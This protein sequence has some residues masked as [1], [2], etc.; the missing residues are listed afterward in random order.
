MARTCIGLDLG[1]RNLRLVA[2]TIKGTVFTVTKIAQAEVKL[3]DDPEAAILAALP[4]L[5]AALGEKLAKKAGGARFGVSGKE[6]IIRYTQVP[7]VPLWRLRL[8]MDFEV[9][10]MAAQA[11]DSLASDYNLVTLPNAGQGEDTVLV[12]VCKESFLAARFD[13]VRAEIGDPESALPAS[14]A[15]FNA[16]VGSGDIHEGEYTFL[17]DLGDRN[18]ELA[19]QRDGELIFARNIATGGRALTEAIAAALQTSVEDAEGLKHQFGSVT[20]RGLATYTSGREEKVGNAI[21]GPVGQLSAMIQSSLAFIRA[22]TKI[23]DLEVGRILLS[24]GGANLR[25]LP[26]YLGAAFHCPVGRFQPEAGLDLTQLEPDEAALFQTDPGS[27]AVALG[28]A[29]TGADAQA[30][31]LDLVPQQTKKKRRFV[32]RSLFMWLAGAAALIFL[33]LTLVREIRA[34]NEL[35]ATASNERRLAETARTKRKLY[36]TEQAKIADLN[37]KM[38]FLSGYTEPAWAL[39]TV[40]ELV[41]KNRPENVWIQSISVKRDMMADAANP[42]LRAPKTR[43][44][45]TGMATTMNDVPEHSLQLLVQGMQAARKGTDVVISKQTPPTRGGPIDF[46]LTVDLRDAP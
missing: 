21:L 40:Q 10:E 34:V 26:E 41:Q 24:G 14:I 25:G 44:R 4:D 28:L 9:K 18:V 1:S 3:G 32:Q 31:S 5:K 29:R 17:V 39:L 43:V 33:V 20:T 7:P 12:A 22:Q 37:G 23:R 36:D 38:A 19:L 6:L 46:E 13:A 15:L 16:F 42:K 8:L 27:F 30:F 11:G 2:G 45:V 35:E